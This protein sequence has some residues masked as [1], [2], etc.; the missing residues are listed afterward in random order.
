MARKSDRRRIRHRL[1]ALI[2]VLLAAAGGAWA[3]WAFLIPHYT[4]VPRVVGLTGTQAT[5]R[6]DAAGLD[7]QFGTPVAS[8]R[9][10]KGNVAQQS[11]APGSRTRTGTDVTLRLSAG[12]PLRSVPAVV[13]RSAGSATK[14]LRR[15]GLHVHVTRAFSDSVKLGRVIEQNPDAGQTI[16]FGSIVRIVVS[17][18]PQPVRVPQVAGQPAGDAEQALIAA[19]FTVEA[20]KVYSTTVPVGDVIR[21]RPAGGTA[22]RGSKITIWVSL[23]PREFP[24]PNVVGKG[25]EDAKRTLQAAGLI[26]RVQVIP[27]SAGTTVVSQIPDSGATVHQGD[28]VTIYVAL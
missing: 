7:T 5:K 1:L 18:G 21:Q 6:L 11:A 28:T 4:K 25:T 26:V 16:P 19:G 15:A 20:R 17:K 14:S 27:G 24:M 8:I 22:D 12:L 3:A 10:P 2:L 13:R 9:V 23:G